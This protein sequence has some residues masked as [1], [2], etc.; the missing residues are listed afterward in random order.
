MHPYRMPAVLLVALLL[1]LTSCLGPSAVPALTPL[2][3]QD[4]P[5]AEPAEDLAGPPGYRD[6]IP[7]D[8]YTETGV[9][10][11]H[12]AGGRWYFELPGDIFGKPMLWH[13]EIDAAPFLGSLQPGAMEFDPSLGDRVIT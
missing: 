8:A 11:L 2:L 3:A 12:Q 6:L 1:V 10:T 4:E 5:L 7:A 13:A 9:F